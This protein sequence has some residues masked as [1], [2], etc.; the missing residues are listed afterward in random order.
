MRKIRVLI[1][2]DHFIVREGMKALIRSDPD[3]EIVGEAGDGEE[4]IARATETK[5]DVILMD[6]AMPIMNGRVAAVKIRRA[7]PEAKILV[8]SS[9]QDEELVREM[10]FAGAVGFLVKQTCGDDLLRAIR[11]AMEGESSFSPCIVEQFSQEKQ[12]ESTA[13]LLTN[14]EPRDLRRT[15]ETR[16][17]DRTAAG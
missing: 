11:G 6:V 14:L 9:Y 13:N 7:V 8:L 2:D 10:V 1:V 15:R 5:P 16:P 4:A 12:Q 3:I 17:K